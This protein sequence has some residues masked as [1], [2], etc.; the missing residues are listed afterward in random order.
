[1]LGSND[2][3]RIA[4][5]NGAQRHHDGIDTRGNG[6]MTDI[7]VNCV[8]KVNRCRTLRQVRISPFRGNDIDFVGKQIDFDMLRNSMAF[9]LL[10]EAAH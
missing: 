5:F 2:F 6:F 7:G 1:M 10:V 8:G 9:E 3:Y 4:G